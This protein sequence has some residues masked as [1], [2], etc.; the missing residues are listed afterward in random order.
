MRTLLGLAV[1]VTALVLLA[2]LFHEP[3]PAAAESVTFESSS[4]CRSCHAEVYDE[5]EESW[6]SKAWVDDEFRKISAEYSNTDCIDCHAPRPVFETGIGQRVLPR[7]SRRVEGVSCLTCHQRP[8]GT[9][10]GTLDNPGAPCRPVATREL[11]APEFCASCHDQH[12]TVQ[13]WKASSYAVPGPGFQSCAD[14]HMPWRDP[15]DPASG[16]DHTMHGGHDIDLVRSAVE[17]RGAREGD[18]WVVE[19]ENVGA[20]HNYPTDERSRASDV[21]WRPLGPDAGPWRHAHRFRNPYRYEG[22]DELEL[23]AGEAVRI[24]LTDA[25]AEGAVEVAL[26]YKLTPYWLDPEAPDPEREASLVHRIELQP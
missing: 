13:Q 16:R 19:V 5:W 1:S 4:D 23:P 15:N 7:A 9:M 14:C 12:K 3:P 8:D 10:A 26:F 25:D 17:L 24:P 18:T 22:L 11:I 20:G 21:F 6:H 2:F